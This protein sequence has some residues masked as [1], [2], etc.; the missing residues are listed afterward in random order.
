M[1]NHC[2]ETTRTRLEKA[3]LKIKDR[4]PDD[5]KT[6]IVDEKVFMFNRLSIMGLTE[7]GMQPFTLKGNTLV[8]NG[9]IYNYKQLKQELKESHKFQSESDCE[10]LLPLYDELGTDMFK[11]LDA[12]FALVLYDKKMNV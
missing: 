12:E 6:M 1:R 2:S 8:A 11:I 7:S 9:E 3:I 5:T 4:G 10:V